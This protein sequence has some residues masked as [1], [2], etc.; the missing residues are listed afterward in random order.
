MATKDDI[1]RWEEFNNEYYRL[2]EEGAENGLVF[3]YSEDFFNKVR[4]YY[5]GGISVPILLL[6]KNMV[7]GYCYDRAPLVTLG[8]KDN[9]F[10]VLYG[11]INSLRLNPNYMDVPG[12]ADHCIV[13]VE[14]NGMKWIIDTSIGLIFEEELYKKLE[15]PIIRL[16]RSKQETIE[17]LKTQVRRELNEDEALI[18][19]FTLSLL[20]NNLEPIQVL[21]EED[22]KREVNL[23]K[24][25]YKDVKIKKKI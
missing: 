15:N 5:Y 14:D 6:H 21:Y 25:K 16:K 23:L 19:S 7:N 2:L 12:S 20:E 22:L 3:P 18:G 17:F 8:F 10:N 11:D 9:D 13:E 24:E 1:K 4:N